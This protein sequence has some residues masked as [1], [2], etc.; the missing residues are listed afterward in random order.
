MCVGR[1]KEL[2]DI[3]SST[4]WLCFPIIPL[5]NVEQ[6]IDMKFLGGVLGFCCRIAGKPYILKGLIIRRDGEQL[7]E[8]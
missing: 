6:P 5:P 2:L 8:R 3:F 1:R 4:D 7:W